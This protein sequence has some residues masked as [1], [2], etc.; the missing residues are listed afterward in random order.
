M[1]VTSTP[2]ITSVIM[3]SIVRSRFFELKNHPC[4]DLHKAKQGLGDV[5][6][7]QCYVWESRRIFDIQR[8]RS[9]EPQF[10]LRENDEVCFIAVFKLRNHP[11]GQKTQSWKIPLIDMDIEGVRMCKDRLKTLCN[12][13]TYCSFYISI[14]I[15]YPVI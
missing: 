14:G 12:V 3:L 2:I 9:I 6:L 1:V 15:F 5:A 8:I 11:T 10:W 7:H 13:I 4:K